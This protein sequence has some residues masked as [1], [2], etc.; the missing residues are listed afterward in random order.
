MRGYEFCDSLSTRIS[1]RQGHTHRRRLGTMSQTC[2][3]GRSRVTTAPLT[4][5]RCDAMYVVLDTDSWCPQKAA[6]ARGRPKCF[7]TITYS[8]LSL[9]EGGGVQDMR[10]TTRPKVGRKQ[11]DLSPNATCQRRVREG[12]LLSAEDARTKHTSAALTRGGDAERLD[13]LLSRCRRAR[14]TIDGRTK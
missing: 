5:R 14:N 3:G 7:E 1:V 9:K 6:S 10:T 13:Q 11:Y 4:R 8:P 12:S 2:V